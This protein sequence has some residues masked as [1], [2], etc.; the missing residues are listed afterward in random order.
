MA[1]VDSREGSVCSRTFQCYPGVRVEVSK[2]KA[3]DPFT[4]R[5]LIFDPVAVS[6]FSPARCVNDQVE[7][8]DLSDD[9]GPI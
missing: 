6:I 2:R 8:E 4:S 3:R 1:F 7:Y 9:D 5:V